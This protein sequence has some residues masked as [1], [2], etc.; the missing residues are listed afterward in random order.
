[1]DGIY[2][3]T[4]LLV[5]LYLDEPGAPAIREMAEAA[6]VIVSSTIAAAEFASALHRH[7]R[8]GRLNGMAMRAVHAQFTA[9]RDAGLIRLLPLT[10]AFIDRTVLVY[11]RLPAAVA[12]R[13]ADALHLATAAEAGFREIHSSDAR[14][15]A[16]ASRFKLKGVNPL[17][18]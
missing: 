12:L 4:C 8:E 17:R 9:D 2:F 18:K 11:Q 15:L 13:A 16:A 14:L 10:E 7:Q 5:K 3:D 6:P 1:M